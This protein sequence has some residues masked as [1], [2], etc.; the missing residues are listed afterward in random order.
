MKIRL[1][2]ILLLALAMGSEV[3]LAQDRT[4]SG[5]VISQ[6]EGTGIPGVNVIVKGTNQGTVTD[7]AGAFRIAVSN[8]VVLVFSFIGYVTEEV[9]TDSRSVIDVEMKQDLKQLQEVVV[10]GYREENRRALPGSIAIVKAD[11][12]QNIPIASF[13][14]VLQ[15]RV[16]GMLVLGGSG[17]PGAAA[18]VIIRGIKS[19]S[20]S[21]GPLYV[22]DGVPVAAGVFN[23]LNTNDFESITVLK[24]ASA[25]TIYGSRGANGVI[26]ITTKRGKDGDTKINYGFQYGVSQAPTN[27]LK[28]MN[29]KEK[30]DFEL[31]TGGTALEDYT[32]EKLNRLRKMYCFVAQQPNPMI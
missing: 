28:V 21:N 31:Q 19:L 27:K 13:D 30:I 4:I 22:I 25:A 8:D 32:S 3:T 18:S 11:K 15:G 9:G 6:E 2:F 12:I 23:T 1:P 24:D 10:T 20:G 7:I 29:S 26:V 17:Q 16:P 5:T 14:Q